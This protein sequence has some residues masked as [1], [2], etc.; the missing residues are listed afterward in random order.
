MVGEPAA[1]ALEVGLE[2]VEAPHAVDE[3]G[4]GGQQVEQRHQRPAQAG[5][6]VLV[7][8]QR[9]ADGDGEGHH[10]GDEGDQGDVDRERLSELAPA[11]R[12]ASGQDG[13]RGRGE[14][15]RARHQSRSERISRR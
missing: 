6:G 12:G 2:V 9:R 1:G 13:R 14:R 5:R 4:H 3:A 8:E 11:A 7:D 15:R 10:Q